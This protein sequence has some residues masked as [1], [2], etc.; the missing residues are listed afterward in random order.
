MPALETFLQIL[1]GATGTGA[2]LGL[3]LYLTL[4]KVRD[5]EAKLDAANA[6]IEQRDAQRLQDHQ[7]A[8]ALSTAALRGDDIDELET[9]FPR[10]PTGRHRRS[11]GGE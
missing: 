11:G 1:G 9:P 4:K 5:L 2:T 8:L 7:G 6:K 10:T 3:W